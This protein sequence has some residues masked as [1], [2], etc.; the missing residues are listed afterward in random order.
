MNRNQVLVRGLALCIGVAA[1]LAGLS[2]QVGVRGGK[3]AS[4]KSGLKPQ[5]DNLQAKA[6]ALQARY[7]ARDREVARRAQSDWASLVQNFE[8]WL[9]GQNVPVEARYRPAE[10]SSEDKGGGGGG[11]SGGGTGGNTRGSGGASAGQGSRDCELTFERPH[12]FCWL[13]SYSFDAAGRK[14]CHFKCVRLP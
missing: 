12:Y 8:K 4:A 10:A 5:I 3:E 14:R 6:L 13:V 11:G 1:G 9:K 7:H 2:A